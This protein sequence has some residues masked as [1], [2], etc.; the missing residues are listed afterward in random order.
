MTKPAAHRYAIYFTPTPQRYEC[1]LGNHW[2]GRCPTRN[3][4]CDQPAI[5]GLTSVEFAALTAAPRRYGWHATLK[6]PF[7]LAQGVS[8]ESLCIAI[9]KLAKSLSAFEMPVLKTTRLGDFLALCPDGDTVKLNATAKACVTDLHHCAAPLS[10]AELQRRRNSGLTPREEELLVRWGYPYVFE[11]FRFHCSLTGP[12][13]E[14]SQQ[15]INAVEQMAKEI[16][17]D[18]PHWKFETLALFLEPSPG[19]DFILLKHFKLCV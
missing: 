14:Y 15:Q 12:F 8:E 11:E 10:S 1:A 3:E 17:D 6:A 5:A 19:A 18:L 13:G 2:L 16:F 9:E 4:A 7:T